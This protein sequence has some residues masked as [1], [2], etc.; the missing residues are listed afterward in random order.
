MAS[1]RKFTKEFKLAA[2]G[3]LRAGESVGLLA[4]QSGGES[5][6]PLPLEPR[7][8]NVLSACLSW[9]RAEADG[10]DAHRGVGT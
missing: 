2:V 6:G 9:R 10:G 8:G 1:R 7:C 5:G 3:R 4:S